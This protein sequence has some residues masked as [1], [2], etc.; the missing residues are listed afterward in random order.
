MSFTATITDED[1]Y[2]MSAKKDTDANYTEIETE[3]LFTNTVGE[4]TNATVVVGIDFLTYY[5]LVIPSTGVI[6]QY[7]PFVILGLLALGFVSFKAY[8]FSAKK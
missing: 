4:P 5:D 3:Y 8:T 7:L 2:T 6:L 1:G